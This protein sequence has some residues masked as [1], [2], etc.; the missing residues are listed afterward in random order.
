VLSYDEAG[1]L[2]PFT[3]GL[4]VVRTQDEPLVVEDDGDPGTAPP[5]L[6]DALLALDMLGPS[7]MASVGELRAGGEGLRLLLDAGPADGAEVALGLPEGLP[8]KA[9][10]AEAVLSG[11]VELRCMT[12]LDVSVPSRTVIQRA[13]GC[14]LPPVAEPEDR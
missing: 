5:V 11:T 12:R 1:P 7:T 13:A 14:D 6:A 10:A 2:L 4:P 8:E 9:Q 3:G